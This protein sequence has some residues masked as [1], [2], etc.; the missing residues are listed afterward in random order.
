MKKQSK[1]IHKEIRNLKGQEFI[2]FNN[3]QNFINDQSDSCIIGNINKLLSNDNNIR[4]LILT[5]DILNKI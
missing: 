1:F 3:L 2:Y 5:K 4:P